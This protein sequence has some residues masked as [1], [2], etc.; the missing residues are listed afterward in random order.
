M[1]FAQQFPSKIRQL[2]TLGAHFDLSRYDECQLTPAQLR[3]IQSQGYI[4]WKRYGRNNNPR[5]WIIRK[6]DLR[7]RAAV[8]VHTPMSRISSHVKILVLH[9]G[10]D[11]I[12]PKSEAKKYGETMAG[13]PNFAWTVLEGVTHA[14]ATSEEIRKVVEVVE[15]WTEG[16]GLGEVTPETGYLELKGAAEPPPQL[17]R[18]GSAPGP[19]A[20]QPPTPNPGLSPAL[21]AE[22]LEMPSELAADKWALDSLTPP[23]TTG[24]RSRTNSVSN[25]NAMPKS[26]LDL[27][28]ETGDVADGGSRRSSMSALSAAL[29]SAGIGPKPVTAVRP[30]PAPGVSGLAQK[31]YK[32][33]AERAAEEESSDSD[34]GF[35]MSP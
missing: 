9:G 28:A 25:V 34:D 22:F 31:P 19:G 33:L 5:F 17:V 35:R 1:M 29:S 4:V 12:V 6:E 20:A 16:E 8:D 23:Y 32:G 18:R 24:A 3:Q 13:R 7:L 14:C 21:L 10:E 26:D 30:V 15:R 11:E 27:L 2:V